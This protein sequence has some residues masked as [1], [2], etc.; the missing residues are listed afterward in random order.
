MRDA[1]HL[2]TQTSSCTAAVLSGYNLPRPNEPAG[3]RVPDPF[4][5]FRDDEVEVYIAVQRAGRHLD[6]RSH[7]ATSDTAHEV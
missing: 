1:R 6:I 4:Q 7:G 3:M 2:S 5:A